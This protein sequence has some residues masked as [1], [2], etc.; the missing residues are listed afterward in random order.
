MPSLFYPLHPPLRHEHAD[1][2]R[3]R[4]RARPHVGQPPVER[5]AE[6]QQPL[7]DGPLLLTVGGQHERQQSGQVGRVAATADTGQMLAVSAKKPAHRDRRTSAPSS[8]RPMLRQ[9]GRTGHRAL[10]RVDPLVVEHQAPDDGMIGVEAE[11]VEAGHALLRAGTWWATCMRSVTFLNVMLLD[12]P[13][14]SVAI[15]ST[16]WRQRRAA[17]AARPR[18][19]WSPAARAS[20][21]RR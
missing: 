4:H 19:C 17:A 13:P 15:P 6:Q 10:V 11:A 7:G 18:A 2:R 16:V 14:R 9:F 8:V 3:Q 21:Q 5:S 20:R 12:L 1:D